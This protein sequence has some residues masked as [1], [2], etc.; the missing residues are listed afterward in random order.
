M[1][2]IKKNLLFILFTLLGVTASAQNINPALY[3]QGKERTLRYKPDGEEFVITNG[4]KRFTRAIYGTNTGFRFETSD[5]PEFGLYM[6]NFGGSVYMAIATPSSTTWIKDMEFIES[7][8]KSGQRTYIVK[9]KKHLGNGTLTIDAVALSDGDGL[10]VKYNAKRVPSGTKILWIYGGANN[11]RFSREGDLGADPADSFFIKGANCK[12]NTYKIDNNTFTLIYGI[13]SRPLSIDEA[14]ENRKTLNM[15]KL[16]TET[17][18]DSALRIRGTFPIGTTISEVDGNQIDQLNRLIQS[19]KS[20]TPVIIAEYTMGTAPFYFELHNPKTYDEI[21]Y[22]E[23]AKVFDNGVEFR[24]KIASTMKVNTPDPFL[25]TLGGIFSGAEDAVWEDPGY[26]HGAIGWRVPLTG[27]RAAYLGD[28]L[29]LQNRAR[30]HFNGYINSQITDVPITLPHLQDSALHLARSAKIWGTPMYSNGY[31]CRYPNTTNLMHHYDMNI[32]FIDELLWH[33][34]WTGDMEYAKQIFP[35]IKRHLDWEKNTYDPNNDGLY[36]AYCCIWA[37]DALQYNGGE[38]THSTAYNY[39]SNKLAADLARKIGEDHTPY[40]KEA[41]RI[42]SAINR[43]LW[44]K[45]KGWWAEFKDNMGHQMRHEEPALWTFYHAI[46]SDVHDPFQAYQASRYVDTKLSNIPVVAKN[47]EDTT[48][49]VV[50][51]TNWQPYMWSI[52]NVA[53]AETVHT[54]LAYW[55]SGRYEEA[56]RLYKGAVLDA[57]YFGS[58]PGNITQVSYY[59]A[60]RGE[61]YRDF[62]D[63]VA[64]AVRAMVQGMFGII[65]DLTNNMLTIRP[66][67]PAEWEFA[68][69]ETQNMIFSYKRKGNSD[70]YKI[71]S[72]FNKPDIEL[73]LELN[74]R[75][76]HLP[77]VKVNGKKVSCEKINHTVGQP[78][79]KIHAGQSDQAEKEQLKILKLKEKSMLLMPPQLTCI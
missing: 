64:M 24:T 2:I 15:S 35:T 45:E 46:D 62:A 59:D 20:E 32:V 72:L 41:E 74:A 9:D 56:Y 36:D 11:Q 53:F 60:A 26:L 48:H 77:S 70:Y 3:W 8:F 47:Y 50:A 23:L 22:K 28:L 43:E 5:F 13:N 78:A 39:R 61:T 79:I 54:A 18:P 25:N 27:W 6:P 71:K 75:F 37:S 42:F 10:V 38:V 34:N 52:N 17:L 58:G 33:L 4:N 49:Y 44:I 7:R 69:L 66:G 68:D 21:T 31:I 29:G 40:E 73:I 65:P 63:P 12:D 30:A 1:R 16:A 51:T 76:D 19:K 55:Q 14:Y 67:L 57:M